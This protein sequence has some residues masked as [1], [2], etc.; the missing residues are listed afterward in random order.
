MGISLVGQEFRQVPVRFAGFRSLRAHFHPDDCIQTVYKRGYRLLAEVRPVDA[1]TEHA[2]PRLAVA[3]FTT[4]TGVPAH[5][6]PSIAEETIAR[7]S[8]AASP[9]VSVLARDST[10]TLA[11]SGLTAHQIGQMLNADLVLTGTL[12]A[13][14]SQFRLRAEMIR[15]EDGSQIWVE[16]LL[17]ARD[18]TAGL[19]TELAERL[20]FRLNS[21]VA[22][23]AYRAPGPSPGWRRPTG[24]PRAA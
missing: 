9:L 22:G 2:L 14:P 18:R 5:L 21:G 15:V 4:G 8:N 7:L 24:R 10:F 12:R 19:E 6:G 17:I 1:P 3:P 16:D 20:F 13:L 11:A 23:D